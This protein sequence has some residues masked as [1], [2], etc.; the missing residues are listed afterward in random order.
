M[1]CDVSILRE[2]TVAGQTKKATKT[3]NKNRPYQSLH[4][5][6][7]TVSKFQLKKES[8]TSTG[9]KQTHL[10]QGNHCNLRYLLLNY[11]IV[12]CDNGRLFYR[13]DRRVPNSSRKTS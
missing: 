12:V 8:N 10:L 13:S 1:S 9:N 7:T 2:K 11:V 5:V 3:S 4:L 6:F